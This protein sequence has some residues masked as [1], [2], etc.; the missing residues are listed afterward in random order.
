MRVD[1]H[2]L[3]PYV[4]CMNNPH[5]LPARLQADLHKDGLLHDP[6]YYWNEQGQVQLN[7]DKLKRYITQHGEPWH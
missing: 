1:R 3:L 5:H 6:D 7:L 2:H 4:T